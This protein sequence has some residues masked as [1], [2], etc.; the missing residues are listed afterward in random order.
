MRILFV[1]DIA[2]G[3]PII[4]SITKHGELVGVAVGADHQQSAARGLGVDVFTACDLKADRTLA[5]PRALDL[6][7]IVNF[8]STIIFPEQLLECP[9]IGAI[10]FHPGLLPDY[11]GLN[12]H[13][14][15]MLNGETETGVTIHVMTPGIDEG[16]IIAQ[17]TV[18]IEAK[19]TGLILFMK[20]L[21]VGAGL[22]AEV[23]DNVTASGFSNA[24]PQ[25]LPHRRVF[26]ATDRPDCR[27]DFSQPVDRVAQF[28]RALSYRPFS[29]PLGAPYCLTSGGELEI[30]S[31][32]T[33]SFETGNSPSPGT[34]MAVD[35]DHME[36]A[37]VDGKLTTRTCYLAG[38][39]IEFDQAAER[40]GLRVGLVL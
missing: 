29:S 6:D 24:R 10:N 7:L 16:P 27:I 20:L 37:C 9:R 26:K 1:G 38:T 35:G 36:I 39:K 15:A 2:S 31:V 13:Q 40:L 5:R 19:D 21:R 22:M 25:D 33:S 12:V 32:S 17:E 8:N 18:P 23:V 4:D 28:I 3:R 11:A 14:W 30:A 34:I